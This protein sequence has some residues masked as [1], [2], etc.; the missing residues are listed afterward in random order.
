MHSSPILGRLLIS[1]SQREE[2][3]V[4]LERFLIEWMAAKG[5]GVPFLQSSA[6]HPGSRR[7]LQSSTI[8]SCMYEH[9]SFSLVHIH[10]FKNNFTPI[11]PSPSDPSPRS[12]QGC[13]GNRQHTVTLLEH[14]TT[15]LHCHNV[16]MHHSRPSSPIVLVS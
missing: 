7:K 6:L 3:T 4:S 8:P 2:Q 9:V 15:I 1:F 10:I 5:D 12:P 11:D 14:N 16:F 13:H